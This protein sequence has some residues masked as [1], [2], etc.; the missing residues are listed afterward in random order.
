[1]K[2]ILLDNNGDIIKANG[3]IAVGDNDEQIVRHLLLSSPG[4]YFYAQ[5]LGAR[6]IGMLHGKPDP[7]WAGN[8][9]KQL[10]QCLVPADEL[11]VD[12]EGVNIK[13]KK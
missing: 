2:G 5:T 3:V 7:F 1:M 8:A 4:N 13:L 12:N 11:S 6:V 10:A 9:K